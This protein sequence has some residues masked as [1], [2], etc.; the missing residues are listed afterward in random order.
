[1]TREEALALIHMLV[2]DSGARASLIALVT[3]HFDMVE[4]V[5]RVKDEASWCSGMSLQSESDRENLQD[6]LNATEAL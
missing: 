4:R 2:S 5:K 1:M 3:H 6:L